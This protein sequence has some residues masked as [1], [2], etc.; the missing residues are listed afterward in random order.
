MSHFENIYDIAIEHNGIVTSAQAKEAGVERSEMARWCRTGRLE[1][2]GHGAYL[3]SC[4]EFSEADSYAQAVAICGPR[5]HLYGESVIALLDL[6]PTDPSRIYVAVPKRLA[7]VLPPNVRTV[8][9][10]A[11]ETPTVYEGIRSQSVFDA[12]M[13]CVHTMLPERVVAAAEEARR[14]GFIS[15]DE[16]DMVKRG[17]GWS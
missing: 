5:A 11:G 9:L 12:L 13:V 2:I 15:R 14:Q 3:V 10:R 1:R 6:A 8:T 7:R 16:R 4:H 17:A